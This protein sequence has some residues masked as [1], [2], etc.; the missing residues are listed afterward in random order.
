MREL[1]AFAQEDLSAFFFD[2]RKDCLYCDA[3]DDPKR[4]AYRTVMDILFH[5]LTRY[6]APVLVFTAEEIWQSRFPDEN[7]SIHLKEWP[8][9]DQNWLDDQLY[10]KW[11]HLIG[12]R[13]RVTEEIEP[14]RRE[15][16]IRSSLEAEITIQA[17][18][19]LLV[20]RAESIIDLADLF[21]VS[22][23][24]ISGFADDVTDS[25]YDIKVTKTD[26]HKCGRCWRLL[27]D[28][29]EDGALCGRCEKVL[30]V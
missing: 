11:S 23:A 8:E 9:V 25:L 14:F 30:S 5:A 16:V 15:K 20:E 17:K 7:D 3:Q 27:P 28:V 1:S 24:S 22:S 26:N 4:M 12:L 29:P 21:I 2:I 18:D 19:A 13:M 10:R 6:I